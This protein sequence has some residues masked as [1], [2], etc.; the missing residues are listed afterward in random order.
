ML[1]EEQTNTN[2]QIRFNST[3]RPHLET[4]FSNATTAV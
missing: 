3:L 4:P 1:W 2:N